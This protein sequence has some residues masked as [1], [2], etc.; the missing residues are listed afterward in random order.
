M[1]V[2]VFYV[3]MFVL[4]AKLCSIYALISEVFGGLNFFLYLGFYVFFCSVN[5][6][7]FSSQDCVCIPCSAVKTKLLSLQTNAQT[8]SFK[9]NF[10]VSVGF[11]AQANI[12]CF[13]SI[14]QTWWFFL[15]GESA[16]IWN[17]FDKKLTIWG[18]AHTCTAVR[19]ETSRNKLFHL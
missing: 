9:N 10:S 17:V 14:V 12:I 2:W 1:I 5:L 3:S 18:S 19:P 15:P 8:C 13:S 11:T 7:W 16:D 6:G 4:K